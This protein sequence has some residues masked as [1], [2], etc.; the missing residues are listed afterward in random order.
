MVTNL[1]GNWFNFSKKQLILPFHSIY[2]DSQKQ[3]VVISHSS[4]SGAARTSSAHAT[5]SSEESASIK[6]KHV[7]TFLNVYV[8]CALYSTT[9][10]IQTCR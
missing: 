10:I 9:K 3:I 8:G 4:F 1:R 5:E 2:G 7:L 6:L